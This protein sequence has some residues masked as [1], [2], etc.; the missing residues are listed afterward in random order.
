MLID[1]RRARRLRL[2]RRHPPSLRREDRRRA[3]RGPRRDRARV[4]RQRG[5]AHRRRAACWSSR[6]RAPTPRRLQR[7]LPAADDGALAARPARHLDRVPLEARSPALAR[8]LR[9]DVRVRVDRDGGR[10]RR[11]ARQSRAR[12][13]A[14]RD[15]LVRGGPLHELRRSRART[16]ARSTCTRRSSAC[17]RW[18]RSQRTARPTS[19]G[20]RSGAVHDRSVDAARRLWPVVWSSAPCSPPPPPSRSR[21]TSA[22]LVHRPWLWPLPAI[23][24]G[25]AILCPRAMTARRRGSRVPA[26]VHVHRETCSDRDDGHA[27]SRAPPI[28]DGQSLHARCVQRVVAHASLVIG[29]HR[30]DARRSRSPPATS[31]T[32]IDRHAAKCR[33]RTNH[34]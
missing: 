24:I 17:S 8:R 13:S 11:R 31:R 33:S 7:A 28:D 32:C 20:R 2:R 10:A 30:L 19:R 12:R 6:S 14:R 5:L 1:V 23:A 29:A 15:G 22:A 25:S 3:T 26:L 18:S 4:G 27:L 9:R 16:S 21:R 34:H